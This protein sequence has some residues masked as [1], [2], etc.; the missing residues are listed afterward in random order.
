MAINETTPGMR[1]SGLGSPVIT[2]LMAVGLGTAIA[3]VLAELLLRLFGLAPVDG[4]ATVTAAEYDE[5]PGIFSPH[6][7]LVSRQIPALPHRVRID[8]LGFRAT[9]ETEASHG[10]PTIL[11]VGDS[12]TF[13]DFVEDSDA[14][15]AQLSAY[16]SAQCKTLRVINAGVGGTTIVDHLEILRRSLSESPDLVILQFAENDVD[17]LAESP[18]FWER[19]AINRRW[20]STIPLSLIYPTFRNT[21]LWNAGLKVLAATRVHKMTRTLHPPSVEHQ[22]SIR[23]ALRARYREALY[24]FRDSVAAHHT[25]LLLVMYPGH[26]SVS[27]GASNQLGTPPCGRGCLGD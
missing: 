18:S 26:Y 2:R 1:P 7:D 5:V 9:R 6:Q 17:D 20:K 11:Y 16:L 27:A 3:L 4:L 14:L 12:F 13:G 19:I 22:D 24:T 10:P 25:H 8:S 23:S 15:P 21:A